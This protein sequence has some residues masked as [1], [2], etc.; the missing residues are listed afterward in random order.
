M[1]MWINEHKRMVYFSIQYML[2]LF[3]AVLFFVLNSM[4]VR[5]CLFEVR[6][7]PYDADT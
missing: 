2:Q 5:F 1:R 6:F 4:M 3:G 7:K